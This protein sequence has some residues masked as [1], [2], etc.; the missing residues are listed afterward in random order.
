MCDGGCPPRKIG[1]VRGQYVDSYS[2]DGISVCLYLDC[3]CWRV[4]CPRM[5]RHPATLLYVVV[6]GLCCEKTSTMPRV[7]GI[8][9]AMPPAEVQNPFVEPLHQGAFTWTLHRA[10]F[11]LDDSQSLVIP[12]L[13]QHS[14]APQADGTPAAPLVHVFLLL[15]QGSLAV[16]MRGNL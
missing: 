9:Q 7:E 14:P 2:P 11:P 3:G 16:F 12:C 4:S 6:V 8:K 15:F 5:I 10:Y 1:L 13:Q